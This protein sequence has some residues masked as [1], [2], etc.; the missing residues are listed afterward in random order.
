MFIRKKCPHDI[1]L[2]KN[3]QT[4]LKFIIGCFLM[5]LTSNVDKNI[6]H[7]FHINIKYI[8][9]KYD[10]F[11]FLDSIKCVPVTSLY[12]FYVKN[13]MHVYKNHLFGTVF[14]LLQSIKYKI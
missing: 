14:V 2:L 1:A 8:L 9:T 7:K 13:Y 10:A 4:L 12:F 5:H 6:N 11:N 3:D